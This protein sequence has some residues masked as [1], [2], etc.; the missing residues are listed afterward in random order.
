[1]KPVDIELR[2]FDVGMMRLKLNVG[3]ELRRALFG[4]LVEV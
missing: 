4:D 2:I 1:L 3:I